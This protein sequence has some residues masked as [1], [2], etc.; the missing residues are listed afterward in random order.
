[1]PTRT[2]ERGPS[3]RPAAT[4]WA[5]VGLAGVAVAVTYSRLPP[6]SFY[7]VSEGGIHGGLGRALVY[8]NFPV[9]LI[10]LAVAALVADR[11]DGRLSDV[12]GAFAVA[13]CL[14]VAA[15]GVVDQNDLDAKAL[16]AIPFFGVLLVLA[17]T[18]VAVGR[19]G[20][21]R[22]T[23]PRPGDPVRLALAALLALAAIPWLFAELGFYVDDVPGLGAVFMSDEIVPEPG[24][25][26]LRA[27]H[28]GH[29]HGTDGV[30]FALSALVLSRELAAIR[31][32]AL[33][34]VLA[35]YLSLMLVYGIANALEDFWLE[36]LVKR[37]V[38]SF[39]LPGMLRPD[40]APEWAAIVLAA[41]LVYVFAF[42]PAAR[43]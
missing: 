37:D 14:V 29:H 21:G 16:N 43:T 9:A 1:M 6:S 33:R 17:L 18:V 36:Q 35:G 34:A 20:L 15:P 23:P 2:T 31:R 27:V 12:A 22:S 26:D 32:P 3:L 42:R 7:N 4:V 24:H 38:T 40:L 30:L 25:P 13:I 28:L 8:S 10:A 5:L 41:A 39:K 11:L 19:A